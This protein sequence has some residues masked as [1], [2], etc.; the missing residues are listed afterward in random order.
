[1]KRVHD[2]V[3]MDLGVTGRPLYA[4]T[5]YLSPSTTSR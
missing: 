2:G 3:G 5:L 4:A 1:V